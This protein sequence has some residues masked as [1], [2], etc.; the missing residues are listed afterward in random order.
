MEETRASLANKLEA[1][2]SQVRDTVQSASEAISS[3][4]D[5]VK[6]VVTT[7][8]DTVGTV[9]DKVVE[10]VDTVKEKVADTFDIGKYVEQSPWAAVGVSVAVGFCA[11]QLMPLFQPRGQTYAGPTH[12]TPPTPSNGAARSSEWGSV[13]GNL[14]QQASGPLQGLAM[15]TVLGVVRELVNRNLPDEWQGELTKMLDNITTELG[16]KPM[17]GNWL[18]ELFPAKCNGHA[19]GQ[20]PSPQ[21][22]EPFNPHANV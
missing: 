11:G 18:A 15:G 10:T 22:S 19:G 12:H 16:G 8:S 2:E 4:V 6:D 14:W 21:G 1:L 17:S 13:L 3:T 20:G 5:G 7:V 9:S